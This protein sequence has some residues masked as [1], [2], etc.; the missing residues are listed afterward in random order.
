MNQIEEG[1]ES[2]YLIDGINPDDTAAKFG[3]LKRHLALTLE[4][5]QTVRFAQLVRIVE[6][7]LVLAHA[8][9]KGVKRPC[10]SGSDMDAGENKHF[11]ILKPKTDWDWPSGQKFEDE[12]GPVEKDIPQ[13]RVFYVIATPNDNRDQFPSVD[14]WLDHWAW[15]EADSEN[16]NFPINFSLRFSEALR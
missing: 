12:S 14:Y 8:I 2:I 6:P 10:K 15:V 1:K 4:R 11:F 3:V 5:G 13:N 16:P 9:F 7:G